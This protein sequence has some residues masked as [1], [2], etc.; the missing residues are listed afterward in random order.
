MTTENKYVGI[1]SSLE[2]MKYRQNCKTGDIF[3]CE[4]DKKLYRYNGEEWE[5]IKIEGEG[6][7]VSLYDL[8]KTV[9]NQLPQYNEEQLKELEE[10]INNWEND[11]RGLG[12]H[13][14]MF[15]C[16]DI[17]YYTIFSYTESS[18]AEFPSLGN[19]VIQ[20]M[21]ENNYTIHADEY[22]TDHLELW[23]KIEDEIYDFLLFPY[24]QGV[25]TY[26]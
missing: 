17:H 24:D 21:K 16:N 6:L 12:I 9:M 19:S 1:E 10:K 7:T 2:S 23:I 25:V 22:C 11:F 18:T 3:L 8:N 4:E 5:P 14:Y 26:G 15:L 13:Y 20:I